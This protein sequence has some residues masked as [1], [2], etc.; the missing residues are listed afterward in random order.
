MGKYALFTTARTE[1][2]QELPSNISQAGFPDGAGNIDPYASYKSLFDGSVN[3]ELVPE[4]IYYC[5]AIVK[6]NSPQWLATP[7]ALGGANG[8]NICMDLIDSYK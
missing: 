8:I 5:N 2:T 7:T 3:A 4:Y 1:R 6:E